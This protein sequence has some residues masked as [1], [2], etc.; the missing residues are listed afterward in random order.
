MEEGFYKREVTRERPDPVLNLEGGGHEAGN[1]GSSENAK[2]GKK[3][4]SLT[5]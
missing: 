5:S 1:V 3:Y 2:G 4:H